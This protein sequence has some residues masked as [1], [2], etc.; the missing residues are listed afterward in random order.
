[1]TWSHYNAEMV[2]INGRKAAATIE[3]DKHTPRI[4][5]AKLFYIESDGVG[6]WPVFEKGGSNNAKTEKDLVLSI[7]NQAHE[8][9]LRITNEEFTEFSNTKD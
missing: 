4:I 9:G 8:R 3:C 2:D 1:M 5:T 7:K 6:G